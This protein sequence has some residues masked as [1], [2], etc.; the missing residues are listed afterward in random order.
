MPLIL[1]DPSVQREL[2]KWEE[3]GKQVRLAAKYFALA[4]ETPPGLYAA[5]SVGLN[6]GDVG[7]AVGEWEQT[8]RLVESYFDAV[9]QLLKT[10][11]EAMNMANKPNA[12]SMTAEDM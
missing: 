8:R 6:D 9:I 3:G 10:H 1:K 11:F 12:E 7:A 4:T 2:E 5:I